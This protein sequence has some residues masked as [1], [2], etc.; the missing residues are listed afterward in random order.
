M[1][2]TLKKLVLSGRH[3]LKTEIFIERFQNGNFIFVADCFVV[4]DVGRFTS[5]AL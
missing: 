3:R 1:A 2:L 5:V 4:A